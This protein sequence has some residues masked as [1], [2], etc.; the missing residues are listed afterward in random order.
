MALKGLKTSIAAHLAVLFLVAM[1]LLD[2]ILLI[3]TRETLIRSEIA[4][5]RELLSVIEAVLANGADLPA[6][7]R[8]QQLE[9]LL[10]HAGISC[11]AIHSTE[12][13]AAWSL[14]RFCGGAEELRNAAQAAAT[15]GREAIDFHGQTFGIFWRQR[16]YV[17]LSTPLRL[18]QQANAGASLQLSLHSVYD[19]LRRTQHIALIYILINTGLLTFLGL[20]RL[21]QITVKPLQ[22]LLNRAQE[23]EKLNEEGGFFTDEAEDNEYSRLSKSLNRMLMRIAQDKQK[24]QNTISSLEEANRNLARTQ[25]EMI[26][27]EKL[28]TVGRLSAGIAHEIGNPI[29]IVKGYLVLL[30]NS[31]IPDK[32]K[33][34][35]IRR[36]EQEIERINSIIR[37]LL[38]FS[39]PSKSGS[40][41][42]AVHG[43]LEE[44]GDICRCQPIFA[45][46][47]MRYELQA[48]RDRVLADP[49]QLRQVFLNLLI[50]SADAVGSGK[51]GT[52]GRL[53]IRTTIA[54]A[55]IEDRPR[56]QAMLHIEFQD[57]GPGIPDEQIGNIFDPFFTTKEPGKGTGLGLSVS[58]SIVESFGGSLRAVNLPLGGLSM[59]V[60]LPLVP[61]G[62]ASGGSG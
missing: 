44:I 43:I 20:Y 1:V 60:E 51:P 56:R 31:S 7:Q 19:M 46:M 33:R 10:V 9:R 28:A 59:V 49:S 50:N 30:Q 53:V 17:Q 34:D 5:G 25:Q 45:C 29:G 21:N 55:E 62:P 24:L 11:V 3:V 58:F 14:G 4:R 52:E 41:V 22:R 13:P 48:P 61:D 27:A 26:R 40:E 57:N 47:E 15:N 16:G 35:F 6:G 18:P 2:F 23:F 54:E 12:M 36:T 8:Q 32:D 42:V 39:R 37:Q 38:D